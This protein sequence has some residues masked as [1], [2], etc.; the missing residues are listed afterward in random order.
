[1]EKKLE[2]QITQEINDEQ[3]EKNQVK[4]VEPIVATLNI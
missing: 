1:M 4:E 2:E 3:E